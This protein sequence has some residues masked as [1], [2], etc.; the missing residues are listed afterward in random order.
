MSKSRKVSKS[1]LL[2]IHQATIYSN[3]APMQEIATYKK[4]VKKHNN[5]GLYDHEKPLFME[6]ESSS[7]PESI[8]ERK[9]FKEMT[10]EEKL[11]YLSNLPNQMLTMKCEIMTEDK[12]YRG[13]VLSYEND[14]VTMKSL[15][16]SGRVE[17]P[18][19][20]I[21]DVRLKGF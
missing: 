7:S 8:G 21:I 20:K 2:Y 10:I 13:V 12:K 14:I 11:T 15:Q 5:P 3:E 17:I 18:A 1:P 6:E 16:R 4:K 9:A 19:N